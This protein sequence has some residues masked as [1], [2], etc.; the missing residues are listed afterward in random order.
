MPILGRLDIDWYMQTF[1]KG[2]FERGGAGPGSLLTVKNK[3]SDEAKEEIRT[4]HEKEF[5]GVRGA[6][7]MMV[8]DQTE[9]TY[10]QFG[11]NRG[12]RDALP[13]ELDHV[14]EARISM[15]FGVP[16]DILGLLIGLDS[17]S[18]ANRRMSWQVL[19]DV[20]MT[21]MLSDLDDV[22]NLS[23][24]PEF[25]GIDEVYF[26]LDDIKALQ[27]DVDAIHERERKNFAAGLTSFEEARDA[28]GRDPAIGEGTLI[29]PLG[30]A[31]T[32][33][34]AVPMRG[35]ETRIESVGALIRAGFDP[36]A[37]LA[38]LGLPSIEHTGAL[39]VTASPIDEDTGAPLAD[40]PALP[41]PMPEEDMPEAEPMPMAAIIAEP[42][43]PKCS[44]RVGANI[45]AGG[46]LDCP[47]G[48]GYFTVTSNG[49]LTTSI[50]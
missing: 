7:K 2:F 25:T 9:A 41:A 8:L 3:L 21:P 36:A 15:I 17:S 43:C 5:G 24:V 30:S 27:E 11:L 22:M 29:V 39:P 49:V 45:Q 48:C 4:R 19:W 47:K 32:P 42:R 20:T 12:L 50:T 46:S 6:N 1:L 31:L 18:Y 13:A 35:M 26:D 14:S 33:V 40:A 28:I 44:R 10:T 34:D 16:A 23:L 38:A 37:S